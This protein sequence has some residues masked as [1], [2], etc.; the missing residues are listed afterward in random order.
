MSAKQKRKPTPKPKRPESQPDLYALSKLLRTDRKPVG[1]WV[2]LGKYS[3][4][5]GTAGYV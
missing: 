1:G 2:G 5:K 3:R 4:L